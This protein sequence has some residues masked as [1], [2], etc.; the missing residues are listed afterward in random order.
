MY[1]C[2]SGKDRLL[3]LMESEKNS[4]HSGERLT[5]EDIMT[6]RGSD[7][8]AP[9]IYKVRIRR[10]AVRPMPAETVG[11]A[12]SENGSKVDGA[13]SADGENSNVRVANDDAENV[14]V[15]ASDDESVNENENVNED[16]EAAAGEDND[17]VNIPVLFYEI[18][19][20]LATAVC[21]VVLVFTLL[22]RAAVVSGYSMEHTLSGGD[23]LIV[24]AIPFEPKYGDIIVFQK[25]DSYPEHEV[26]V[27]RVIATEGQTVDIDFD[28]WT[29]TVDGKVIDESGYMYIAPDGSNRD[30]MQFPVTV[31]E[32]E[33]F[34]MG[35]NR[36]HSTDSREV[37]LIDERTVFGR[38]IMRI[39]PITQFRIFGRF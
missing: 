23:V 29:V 30:K 26:V 2:I 20:A 21:M 4:M 31:G 16:E 7:A 33:L 6:H 25:F 22:V 17:T 14:S 28:T 37:G 27:K 10:R 12:D 11:G 15:A 13:G 32:G 1:E 3:F 24:S 9:E 39:S 18:T 35:D 38:V 8:P 34:V 36:K 5:D 19:E